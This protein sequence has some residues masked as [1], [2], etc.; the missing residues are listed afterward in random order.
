MKKTTVYIP[1]ELAETMRSAARRTGTS[2][3]SLIREAIAAYVAAIERPR[4]KSIGIVADG[5]LRGEDMEDWINAN[6]KPE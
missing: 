3:A 4:P 2:E 6:W 1:D 5:S